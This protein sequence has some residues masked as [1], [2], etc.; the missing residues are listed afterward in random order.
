MKIDFQK[1]VVGLSLAL[2][3]FAVVKLNRVNHHCG[4]AKQVKDIKKKVNQFSPLLNKWNQYAERLRRYRYLFNKPY[5]NAKIGQ[6]NK[7]PNKIWV[8]WNTELK[9][10]PLLVQRCVESMRKHSG[11][12][13]VIVL[14]PNNIADYIEFPKY[15]RE[16]NE[17]GR[18]PHC[19]VS[20][21][22]LSACLYEYGGTYFDITTYI[23]DVPQE[24]FD[25]DI[26]LPLDVSKANFEHS[27]LNYQSAV[28]AQFAHA[29]EPGQYFF[30]ITK[31]FMLDSI[32]DLGGCGYHHW[33]CFSRIFFEEDSMFRKQVRD[34]LESSEPSI[35]NRFD[36]KAIYNRDLLSY[37][38]DQQYIKDEWERI[39]SKSKIHKLSSRIKKVIPGSFLDKLI[40]GELD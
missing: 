8:Y 14:N 26:C 37:K 21:Y 4:I 25:Q 32:R 35:V 3:T 17:K 24:L 15:M 34:I 11:G 12:R 9:D 18:M 5:T 22:V 2:A 29:K 31:Q 33:E 38:K 40:K 6:P 36:P 30:Y 20:D 19:N 1:I 28:S 23:S 27:Y 10:S 13:E 16:A 7:Y 39:K